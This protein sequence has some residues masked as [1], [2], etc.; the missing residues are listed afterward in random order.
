VGITFWLR[1]YATVFTI[2]FVV[3]AGAQLLRGRVVEDA[4]PHALLWAALSAAVFLATR[5]YYAR[6]GVACAIC[7]DIPE[8]ER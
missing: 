7:R 4:L 2:A 5:L 3:I 8:R 1:R 6:R